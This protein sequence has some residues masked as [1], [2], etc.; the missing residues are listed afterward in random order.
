VIGRASIGRRQGFRQRAPRAHGA[1]AERDTA[2][3]YARQGPQKQSG[4]SDD[5]PCRLRSQPEPAL[6]GRKG[7]SWLKQTVPLRQVKLR[8]LPKADWLFVLSCAA[9]NLLLCRDCWRRPR[10]A[11]SVPEDR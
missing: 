3:D 4:A 6:A 11:R 1:G 7:L 9:H 5:T 2:C 10:H 8:G